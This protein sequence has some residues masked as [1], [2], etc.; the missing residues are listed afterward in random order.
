VENALKAEP[1]QVTEGQARQMRS[2]HEHGW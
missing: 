2:D 1:L